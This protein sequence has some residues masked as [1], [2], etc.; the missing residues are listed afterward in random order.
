MIHAVLADDE[1]LARQKLQML[2]RD[3]PEIEIVGESSTATETIELVLATKPEILFLDIRMPGMDGF[4]IAAALTAETNLTMPSSHSLRKGCTPRSDECLRELIPK[5]FLPRKVV[6][7]VPTE[8]NSPRGWCSSLAAELSSSQS[9]TFDGSARKRTT[10]ASAR[11]LRTISC[12]KR[13]LISRRDL[14]RRCFSAYTVRRLS[15]SNT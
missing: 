6:A 13:W 5:N 8:T 11:I 3:E 7:P 10:Y 9:R 14:I 1:V 15:I 2:L 12:A 4:D